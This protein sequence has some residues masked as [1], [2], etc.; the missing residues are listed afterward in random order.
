MAKR[1]GGLE[2]HDKETKLAFGLTGKVDITDRGPISAL[3]AK[4]MKCS[5]YKEAGAG[6]TWGFPVNSAD[7]LKPQAVGA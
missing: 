3:R 4:F 2:A 5:R 6:G 1:G 7:R